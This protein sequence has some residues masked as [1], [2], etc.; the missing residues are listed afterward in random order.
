MFTREELAS[1]S[2]EELQQLGRNLGIEPIGNSAYPSSWIVPLIAA[3]QRG[4]E[5]CEN[6]LGLRRFPSA[7][8]IHFLETALNN[9]GQPT[10]AQRTLIKAALQDIWINR[11]DYRGVQ[12]RLFE[13]WQVRM[14]LLEALT[15]LK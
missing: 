14:M 2:L 11:I 5:D 13:V 15:R 12:Q 10:P 4:V 6:G 1:K 7:T 9:L 3:A 8:V